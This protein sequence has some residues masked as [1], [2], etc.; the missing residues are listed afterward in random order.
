MVQVQCTRVPIQRLQ[1]CSFTGTCCKH[2]DEKLQNY[3]VSHCSCFPYHYDFADDYELVDLDSDKMLKVDLLLV[4]SH[5]YDFAFIEP[6][7]PINDVI[8]SGVIPRFI[9]FLQQNENS[10]LQVSKDLGKLISI[11]INYRVSKHNRFF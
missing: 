8:E 4:S 1:V 3:L 7:P 5:L 11:Y 10:V 2:P 9:Q 6:N